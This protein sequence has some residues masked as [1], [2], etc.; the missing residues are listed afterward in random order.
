MSF[1]GWL[2]IVVILCQTQVLFYYVKFSYGWVWVYSFPKLVFFKALFVLFCNILVQKMTT[3][4]LPMKNVDVCKKLEL[5]PLRFDR[6]MRVLSQ[7]KISSK[8]F[9][10]SFLQTE[11]A[12]NQRVFKIF[13]N[14]STWLI[15]KIQNPGWQ[16]KSQDVNTMYW[17]NNNPCDLQYFVYQIWCNVVSRHIIPET[18][19][20]FI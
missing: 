6:D 4:A 10:S 5:N 2:V 3:P 16:R 18:S 1:C 15:T 12:V 8:I 7:K 17:T 19:Q 13:S 20:K 11:N 14:F 9:I